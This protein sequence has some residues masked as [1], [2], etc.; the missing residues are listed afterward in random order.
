MCMYRW[1]L[2][3]NFK[4]MKTF[5]TIMFLLICF[6]VHHTAFCQDDD[7]YYNQKK[8]K[9]V[10]QPAEYPFHM[11]T[12]VV[13]PFYRDVNLNAEAALFSSLT[14]SAGYGIYFP[15]KFTYWSLGESKRSFTTD[16][17]G[18]RIVGRL[19]YYLFEESYCDGTFSGLAFSYSALPG[20]RYRE[21]ILNMGGVFPVYK[22]IT[23]TFEFGLSTTKYYENL[24]NVHDDWLNPGFFANVSLGYRFKN[25]KT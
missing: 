18:Y 22:N 16:E 1:C 5:T 23:F 4:M 12:D 14:V 13:R 11:Y 7:V 6:C 3:L 17:S 10:K 2:D 20:L 19:R 15:G 24:H 9:K 25:K 21:I 8:Q